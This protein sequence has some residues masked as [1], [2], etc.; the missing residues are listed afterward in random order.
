MW[1]I[2]VK[3]PLQHVV[4][5]L[6]RFDVRDQFRRSALI[7]YHKLPILKNHLL[8]CGM[9]RLDKIDRENVRSAEERRGKGHVF[10]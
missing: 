2:L 6:G 10:S 1:S 8:M 9:C 3:L 5:A 4:H 7:F